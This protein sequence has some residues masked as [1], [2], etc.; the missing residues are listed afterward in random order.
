MLVIYE[1]S[2]EEERIVYCTK[3]GTN[4]VDGTMV[5]VQCGAPLYGANGESKSY[6]RYVRYEGEYVFRRRSGLLAGIVIGLIILFAGFSLLAT[7]L[8]EIDVPWGP[9]IMIFFGVVILV[10]LF[11]VRSRRR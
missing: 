3:C 10:R 8:Y 1:S 9:L 4:H 6:V 7:E 11:Q 5:C 2:W